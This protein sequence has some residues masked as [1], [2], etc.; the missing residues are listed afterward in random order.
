MCI[1][2][3]REKEPFAKISSGGIIF[4][5]F[6]RGAYEKGLVLKATTSTMTLIP[7]AIKDALGH[8]SVYADIMRYTGPS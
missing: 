3:K 5:Y 4:I 6:M 2:E 8:L 1:R 7:S